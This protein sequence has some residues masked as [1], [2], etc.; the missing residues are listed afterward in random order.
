MRNGPAALAVVL[1]L[2]TSTACT[3]DSTSSSAA[4]QAGPPSPTPSSLPSPTTQGASPRPATSE[5]GPATTKPLSCVSGDNMWTEDA[6]GK[7]GD[8]LAIARDALTDL[9]PGDVVEPG[10]DDAGLTS[11]RIVRGDQEIGRLRFDRDPDGGWLLSDWYV[12]AGLAI[13][14]G[15]CQMGDCGSAT[16]DPTAAVVGEVVHIIA[17]DGYFGQ[18]TPERWAEWCGELSVALHEGGDIMPMTGTLAPLTLV[19]ADTATFRVPDVAAGSYVPMLSCSGD[20]AFAQPTLPETFT[21][22][23]SGN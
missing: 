9:Q 1:L 22:L 20:E 18:W 21:V 8:L 14:S 5:G 12:C 19:D 11:I 6:Q 13:V 10:V 7:Q 23:P 16:L 2:L 15:T 4:S 3:A 17:E